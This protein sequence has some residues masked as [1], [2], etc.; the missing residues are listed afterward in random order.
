M[1]GFVCISMKPCTS[2]IIALCVCMHVY[3]VDNDYPKID[4]DI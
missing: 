2:V 3:V 4:G 1:A